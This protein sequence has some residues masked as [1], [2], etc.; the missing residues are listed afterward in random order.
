MIWTLGAPLVWTDDQETEEEN[1]VGG[2][3][4]DLEQ[5]TVV[6]AVLDN[7]VDFEANIKAEKG[8][9]PS[10]LP[11]LIKTQSEH[12]TSDK[13]S[14]GTRIAHPWHSEHAPSTNKSSE[15]RIAKPWL[16]AGLIATSMTVKEAGDLHRLRDYSQGRYKQTSDDEI[17]SY[18][19]FM[20]KNHH[21][22]KEVVV[23]FPSQPSE[24]RSR[25]PPRAVQR[26]SSFKTHSEH[27]SSASNSG[28][29]P[30]VNHWHSEHGPLVHKSSLAR[31]VHAKSKTVHEAEDLDMDTYEPF[32]KAISIP[33]EFSGNRS[34]RLRQMQMKESIEVLPGNHQKKTHRR[35]SSTFDGSPP[36]P[37]KRRPPSR[38]SKSLDGNVFM[39]QLGRQRVPNRVRRD[40][41][42][43]GTAPEPSISQ[44]AKGAPS[45]PKRVPPKKTKSLAK[46]EFKGK[47]GRQPHK[48]TKSLDEIDFMGI[49][50]LQPKR[51]IHSLSKL[52]VKGKLGR[53]PPKAAKSLEENVFMGGLGRQPPKVTHSLAEM[54]FKDQLGR[55]LPKATKSL[56][57]NAFV[58]GVGRHSG[59][60]DLKDELGRHSGHYKL[61]DDTASQPSKKGAFSR[62]MRRNSG[63][64]HVGPEPERLV[65]NI[66]ELPHSF[67]LKIAKAKETTVNN[68]SDPPQ[69]S[70]HQASEPKE[71]E[72]VFPWS[73]PLQPQVDGILNNALQERVPLNLIDTTDVDEFRKSLGRDR[74]PYLRKKFAGGSYK[75]GIDLKVLA[76]PETGSQPL[77][78][79][80]I[81]KAVAA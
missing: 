28:L 34:I 10:S 72:D 30:A 76:V 40:S 75:D 17:P 65:N 3:D 45:P 38:A 69:S 24:D 6:T 59:H 68:T 19:V 43:S 7:G 57:E 25:V 55:Q 73:Q 14:S 46:D 15:S 21:P 29:P 50:N 1:Y 42:N 71:T 12:V 49:L 63:F 48:A 54:E 77:Q 20:G 64:A 81:K 47:L 13:K 35:A 44:E 60:Y 18:P 51:E 67:T 74:N 22:I 52:D 53:Q 11:S 61:K 62:L 4:E 80:P 79:S 41:N 78:Q 66:S 31:I 5:A 70:A 2:H 27:G 58:G 26:Q 9:S 23:H 36:I 16:P 39:G 37:P 33:S 56:G 8:D 32:L